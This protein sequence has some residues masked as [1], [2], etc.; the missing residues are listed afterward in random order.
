MVTALAM[1]SNYRNWH[2]ADIV[3]NIVPAL[4]VGQGKIF[5]DDQR[6]PTAFVTWALVDD[7]CHNNL[8]CHGQNPPDDRWCSGSHLWFIDILAP[9]NNVRSIIRDIQYQ[10]FPDVRCAYSIR[11]DAAGGIRRVNVWKSISAA[12]K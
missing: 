3:H 12:T 10:Q 5:L 6:R 8:R 11:R 7:E 1:A 9:F 4:R 2:V